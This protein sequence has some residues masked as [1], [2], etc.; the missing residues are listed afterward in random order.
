VNPTHFP[1]ANGTLAGGPGNF[2]GTAD[3]VSD[4]QVYRGGGEII[5]CWK[6]SFWERLVVLF[7]GRVWLRVWGSKT[8]HPVAIGIENPWSLLKR[9]EKG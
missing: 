8:H 7:K 6:A 9:N 5:S 1:E 3:D 4:L 2:F